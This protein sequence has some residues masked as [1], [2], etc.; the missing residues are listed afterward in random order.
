MSGNPLAFRTTIA[1]PIAALTV[2]IA[3]GTAVR[4]EPPPAAKAFIKQL[5]LSQD[6]LK[7]WEDEHKV[8]AEW[9]E[10]AKKEDT[11][12]IYGSWDNKQFRDMSRAFSERYP[13]IK[14]SYTRGNSNTR[15]TKPLI[16][17]K[18]GRY[19][20]DLLTGI[21]GAIFL[22]REANALADLKVLP[23]FGKLP[24][25]M[26]SES[27]IWA[28]LRTRYWCMSYNPKLISKADM[29]KRWEDLLTAEKLKDGK[30]ALGRLPQ[31]WLLPLWGTKG[32]EW[33]TD[34]MKKIF[35]QVRPQRRKEGMNALVNLVA[36][37]E[38]TAAV[39]TAGYRVKFL[40][41][42]GAPV[43]W[44]CPEPVPVA[45]SEAGILRNAPNIHSAYLYMNWLL[46]KEGQLAQFVTS[47]EAP[48]HK[49]LFGK[50]FLS[51]PKEIEGKAIAF[52]SP[53]LL[54]NEVE[55]KF[56]GTW[57]PL[58]DNTAK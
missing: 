43:A 28:G 38:F 1:A 10:K 6:V 33:T 12:R 26:G 54:G 17:F 57:T 16:A 14:M 3:A 45:I 4:A 58:W 11:L 47:A 22:F 21:G 34:Y 44:H 23:N 9:V 51:L 13:F 35:S 24:E 36:A 30:L 42:K 46:S 2:L 40:V 37:G 52:R 49:E 5:K 27:G 20:A 56:F 53:E 29:P 8:P 41:D 25:G 7:G 39:A 55:K 32:E 15:V 31:L 48:A 50:G 18:E 19:V